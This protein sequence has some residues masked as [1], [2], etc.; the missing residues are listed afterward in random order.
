MISK[1]QCPEPPSACLTD[2]HGWRSVPPARLAIRNVC[3]PTEPQSGGEKLRGE[4]WLPP[5]PAFLYNSHAEPSLR[6]SE[7]A[8]LS[9]TT[10]SPQERRG[11]RPC[12]PTRPPMGQGQWFPRPLPQG[13]RDAA[14]L[15]DPQECPGSKRAEG[16]LLHN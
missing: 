16:Q 5:T 3:V 4:T 8:C 10:A 1:T 6:G 7:H 12:S 9:Q 14:T 11:W 15:H 2:R 13:L